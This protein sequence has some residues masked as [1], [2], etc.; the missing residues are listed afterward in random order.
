MLINFDNVE[1][2]EIENIDYTDY[3]DFCDAFISNAHW[4]DTGEELTPEELDELNNDSSFVY[5]E[6]IRW[7][8]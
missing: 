6:V 5:E 7:V 3:P 8:F 1:V 4:K 2:D